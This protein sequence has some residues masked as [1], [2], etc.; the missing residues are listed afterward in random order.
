LIDLIISIRYYSI[1]YYL[2][3]SSDIIDGQKFLTS[4]IF[5]AFNISPLP[6]GGAF[7]YG[8]LLQTRFASLVTKR[9]VLLC[10]PSDIFDVQAIAAE[11]ALRESLP[12]PGEP[13]TSAQIDS[14]IKDNWTIT[15]L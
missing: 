8:T 12:H 4:I 7:F 15:G 11:V 10:I 1:R 6:S 5:M 3:E 14:A 13:V 9:S 2:I